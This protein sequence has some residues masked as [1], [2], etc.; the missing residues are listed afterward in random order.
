MP[1]FF[2]GRMCPD[3]AITDVIGEELRD[4]AEATNRAR[5]MRWNP[6]LSS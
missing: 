3:H 5:E 6:P 1:R 4:R 2:F